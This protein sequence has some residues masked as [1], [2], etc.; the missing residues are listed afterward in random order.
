MSWFL[1]VVLLLLF[2]FLLLFTI[3]LRLFKNVLELWH[4]VIIFFK[5]ILSML[6]VAL[7][8]QS[9]KKSNYNRQ[10]GFRGERDCVCV[11]WCECLS[12]DA[13]IPVS[14]EDKT[15][16]LKAKDTNTTTT[17]TIIKP[18][19]QH[20]A[21]LSTSLPC[22]FHSTWLNGWLTA[23]M[24]VWFLARLVLLTKFFS[25]KRMLG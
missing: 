6:F 21:E 15:S 22:R 16:P 7:P 12:I 3:D 19:M 10:Q 13:A 2:L 9:A 11:W 23:S 20:K 8:N 4:A 18:W 1:V 24:V 5:S 25:R 14:M 17:T